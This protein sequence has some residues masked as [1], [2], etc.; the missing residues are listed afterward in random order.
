MAQCL[1]GFGS[2]LG[3][4]EA[5]ILAAW[6]AIASFPS[7]GALRLSRLFSTAPIGGPAGQDTFS[8][9]V[10]LVETSLSPEDL[11]QRLLELE[12]SLGR[13]RI[14]HWG[15]RAIDLD[16][17]T[18]DQQERQSTSLTLPHPR[19]AFRR[20]VLEPAADVA[21]DFICPPNGWSVGQLLSHLNTA[22][23]LVAMTAID[24]TLLAS[25]IQQIAQRANVRIL[26][27]AEL[28]NM[29]SIAAADDWTILNG[30]PLELGEDG[31]QPNAKTPDPKLVVVI[32]SPP[33]EARPAQT[34]RE[35]WF[36]LMHRPTVGPVL[37]LRTADPQTVADEVVAAM[38]AMR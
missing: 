13:V 38:A 8:N 33:D 26:G 18:Y 11:L 21:P 34:R 37:W 28:G 32:D 20:F 24:E 7:T 3:D 25:A 12:N 36:A 22:A 1:V 6:Q 16:L 30:W 17:L 19:L 5:T 29:E 31:G 14:E 4:R 15:P 9:A 23:P 10:G 35:R 2:N 27:K